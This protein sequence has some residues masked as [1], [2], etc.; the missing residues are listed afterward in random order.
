MRFLI[1]PLLAG[2]V[3]AA[4]FA[5]EGRSATSRVQVT[6][7][8][9][10]IP[11]AKVS[12]TVPKPWRFWRDSFALDATALRRVKSDSRGEWDSVYG[13]ITNKI[14]PFADCLLHIGNDF[15][16]SRSFAWADLQMR[17]Y[18]TDIKPDEITEAVATKGVKIAKRKG[19]SVRSDS[20]E[21]SGWRVDYVGFGL[22]YGD[23][24]GRAGVYFYSRPCQ[25]RTLV[26]VFM[27]ADK[28]PA[29]K[30]KDSI[31]SSFRMESN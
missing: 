21:E 2:A 9:F 8:H 31:L 24:G 26:L 16:G 23:Y 6:D 25:G 10:V 12:F 15:W 11:E 30:D 20:K 19:Q 29:L 27:L 28:G 22:W 17:A 14:L 3:V 18:L 7:G 13:P 4:A 1:V 5:D